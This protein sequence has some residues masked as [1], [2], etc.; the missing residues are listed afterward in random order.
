[1][2][3]GRVP[4]SLVLVL[5]VCWGG[6]SRGDEGKAYPAVSIGGRLMIDAAAY[7]SD[8]VDLTSGA[9]VRRARV[10]VGGEVRP[11]WFFKLQY[12]LVDS[13]KEGLR[14]AYL[15]YAG[16][17]EATQLRIGQISEPGS[18]EDSSSSKYI[19]FMERALPV[20]AFEPAA[21]RLGARWDTHG[22]SWAINA[23]V[24]E[25]NAAVDDDQRNGVGVSSRLICAPLNGEGRVLHTAIFGAYRRTRE[26]DT[27]RFRAR[28][29]AH[30]DDTRLVDTGAITNAVG[31]TTAGFEAAW[32]GG[33]F[34]LQGE[35]IGVSVDRDGDDAPLLHGAYVYG[36][37][38][39][40]GESR[41]Y[42]VSDGTFGKVKPRHPV[43]EGGAG[44]WEIAA[45][46][47][48]L[49]LSDEVDGGEENNITLGLN[50]YPNAHTRFMLN[51]VRAS[52][53]TAAGD[54]DATIVQARAQV[55]F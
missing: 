54:V 41:P 45:R 30:V 53:E 49:D 35:L 31:Y 22:G 50:W 7:D 23:G 32:V 48:R 44:A 34:S 24:F 10:Y 4:W 5:A 17:G 16:L 38:F 14:D 8:D 20:L 55:I 33:P 52:A 29:E 42:D 18:L 2:V 9:E 37:W 6:A 27:V 13:G 19:T 15:G 11:D 46:A 39:L 3:R 47:S 1:M 25:E 21:R 51:A 12:D 43:D 36:S 26:D 40:T 28:P